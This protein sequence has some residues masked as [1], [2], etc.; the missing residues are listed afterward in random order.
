MYGRLSLRPG[1]SRNLSSSIG[2][3][4]IPEAED[5]DYAGSSKSFNNQEPS[6]TIQT[7][8]AGLVT[9][10]ILASEASAAKLRPLIQSYLQAPDPVAAGEKTVVILTSKVAQKSYGTEKR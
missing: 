5:E 8:K 2:P 9:A 10:R 1:F 7:L 6:G 3:P 4:T